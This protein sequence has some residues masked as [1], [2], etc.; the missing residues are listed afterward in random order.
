MPPFSVVT[1]ATGFVGIHLVRALLAAGHRVA[2]L[3]RPGP[4]LARLEGLSF[5]R[6]EGDLAA[7][8]RH[9]DA[10]ARADYVFHVAGITKAVRPADYD[11][12]NRGGTE[13]VA[14]LVPAGSPLRRFVLVSSL[15]AAGPGRP[16]RPVREDDPPAPRTAY[17]R[18]K[19]GGEE[20]LE[21]L[22]GRFPWAIVRPPAIYGPEDRDVL[23]YFR[24]V[25]R[26]W[27]PRPG[28]PEARISLVHVSDV[29]AGTL[30]AAEKP[31][32]VGRTYFVSSDRGFTWEEMGEA[33]R[34]A[35]GRRLRVLPVPSPL[36]Y[37]AAL[38][39]EAA[40][41]ITRRPPILSWDKVTDV[42]RRN[43]ECSI[44][45]ARSELGYAPRY[46]IGEGFAETM[47]WYR[48]KG[49]L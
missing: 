24:W 36:L 8:G 34:K 40:S 29:V 5:E 15:A 49:W 30:L 11:R 38:L 9:R 12:V 7:A 47:R 39:S 2:G 21:R 26:G 14:S 33:M 13:A 10:F 4:N 3:V 44:E 46:G 16:G 35:A 17:G 6:L 27:L 43:W 18:S 20:V 37:G 1:G 42:R 32:A 25:S 45:R 23:L 28:R 31:A 41:R 19:R 48:D 22:G